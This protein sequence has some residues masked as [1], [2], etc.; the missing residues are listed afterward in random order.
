MTI[1]KTGEWMC[2]ES[3]RNDQS[4]DIL[5]EVRQKFILNF[6][7]IFYKLTIFNEIWETWLKHCNLTRG[8]KGAQLPRTY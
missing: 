6:L 5:T 1:N 2:N 7:G 8:D 3:A 4:I